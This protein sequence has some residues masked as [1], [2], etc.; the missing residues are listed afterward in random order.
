MRGRKPKP[1]YLK[2]VEG[3]PGKRPIN[4]D[5]P[6]PDG[7]LVDPPDFLN[8]R[9]RIIWQQC[10]RNSPPG[11]LKK[12]DTGI[13][14]TYVVACERHEDAARRVDKSG[15]IVAIAGGQWAHNPYLSVLN[16]QAA[17]MRAAIS[18]LGFSPSSRSRVKVNPKKKGKGVLGQLRQLQID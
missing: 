1:T 4:H 18:E 2:L 5:E 10:I 17:I 11:M 12:L 16:K 6:E 8:A 7:D 13:L 3:N 15:S 9:Q 14:Q